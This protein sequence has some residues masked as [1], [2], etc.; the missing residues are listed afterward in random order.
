MRVGESPT[1]E[2]SVLTRAI[3]ALT[4]ISQHQPESLRF[5]LIAGPAPSRGTERLLRDYHADADSTT[6]GGATRRELL[7]GCGRLE[8]RLRRE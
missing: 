3:P 7:A 2:G 5:D 4:W 6:A 8:G 1:H